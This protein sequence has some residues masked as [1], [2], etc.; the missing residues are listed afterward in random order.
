MQ[1]MYKQY[2]GLLFKLA[3]QL[4]GSVSDAEDVVHDVFIRINDAQ[5]EKLVEPKAYLYKMVTNRCRDL[6]KSARKRRE[7]YF[8]DWLPEPIRTDDDMIESVVRNE[9]LSYATLVLLERLTPSER[10]V[11]VLRAAFGFEYIELAKLIDK[12]EVNCRKLFSRATAK[13]SDASENHIYSESGSAAN[14]EVLGFVEALKQGDLNRILAMLDR[15]VVL[16]SDGGGKALAA[17]NPIKSRE[18]V[19][20]FLLGVIRKTNTADHGTVVETA[21]LNGQ[22]ALVLRSSEGIHTVGIP[23]VEKN[24][25]QTIYLIRNPDK[26]T[27]IGANI[28]R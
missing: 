16:V 28:L 19:A 2:K 11:F 27:H 8:G 22:V 7:R 4:T 12:S 1:E 14:E 13:M 26:L 10:V 17:V 25:I 18:H 6:H 3:Y 5:P 24:I 20:R 23:H 15:N 21:Y 9:L